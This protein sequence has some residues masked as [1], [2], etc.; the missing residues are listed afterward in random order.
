MAQHGLGYEDL[1][2]SESDGGLVRFLE[3]MRLRQLADRKIIVFKDTRDGLEQ[4]RELTSSPIARAEV[5]MDKERLYVSAALQLHYDN[6]VNHRQLIAGM[7][8]DYARRHSR[9]WMTG[10]QPRKLGFTQSE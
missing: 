8:S 9:D 6:D 7:K 4:S 1:I 5:F 3:D 2:F 10:G